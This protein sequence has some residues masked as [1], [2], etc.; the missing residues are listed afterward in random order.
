MPVYLLGAMTNAE[1]IERLYGCY[2]KSHRAFAVFFALYCIIA[3][4]L[5]NGIE[6]DHW[7]YGMEYSMFRLIT[8]LVFV[9]VW[10]AII[11]AGIRGRR[12]MHYSFFVYCMHV[13]ALALFDMIYKHSIE[14][15]C[16][17]ELMKYFALVVLTYMACVLMAMTMEKFTPKLWS[18]LNGKR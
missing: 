8:P 16:D 6:K 12:W 4:Y 17:N 5:P 1:I 3:W 7:I 15:I 9:M 14:E 13:P 10:F 18:L 11:T 2:L